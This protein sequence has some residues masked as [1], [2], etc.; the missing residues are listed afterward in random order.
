VITRSAVKRKLTDKEKRKREVFILQREI[1][2]EKENIKDIETIIKG[3][4]KDIKEN[5][6]LLSRSKKYLQE[7]QQELTALK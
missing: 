4:H 6:I 7:L 2:E 3:F 1:K 5:V